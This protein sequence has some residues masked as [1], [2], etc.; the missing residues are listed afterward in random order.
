MLLGTANG[1]VSS[2][3]VAKYLKELTD[4]FCQNESHVQLFDNVIRPPLFSRFLSDVFLWSPMKQLHI[5]LFCP[6]HGSPLQESVWTTL[7]RK[8][9]NQNPRLKYG[10][11]RNVLLIQ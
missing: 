9:S 4:R 10:L 3:D 1:I 2:L 6:I 8:N 5:Q 7:S 11:Q